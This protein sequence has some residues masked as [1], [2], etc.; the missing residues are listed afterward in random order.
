MR[1]L[2]TKLLAAIAPTLAVFAIL[3][4]PASAAGRPATAC[5]ANT[6]LGPSEAKPQFD[7]NSD[8]L[9]CQKT[10]PA[11]KVIAVRERPHVTW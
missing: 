1:S 8:G 2:S 5:P 10:N 9:V 11:G 6:Y 7:T 3:S 4:G